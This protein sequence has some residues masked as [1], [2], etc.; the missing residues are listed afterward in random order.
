MKLRGL[1]WTIASVTATGIAVLLGAFDARAQMEAF[2]D[3][4]TVHA[5]TT[6]VRGAVQGQ[7]SSGD[8]QIERGGANTKDFAE[9]CMGRSLLRTEKVVVV[10]S[11]GDATS[12]STPALILVVDTTS[13]PASI[14]ALLG[15]ATLTLVART[16]S[17]DGETTQAEYSVQASLGCMP[18]LLVTGNGYA[19]VKL[20]DPDRDDAAPPN[21]C[22]QSASGKLL[23]TAEV[24]SGT[25]VLESMSFR[26]GGRSRT[27][28][29]PAAALNAL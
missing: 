2:V 12:A 5:F 28:Q 18:G 24:D 1:Q 10:T 16:E 26:A 9:A 19:K 21:A 17:S 22:A 4:T 20:T 15:A 23:G 3:P 27:I 11:C 29:V 6:S 8:D 7:K 13:Q 25:A 14:V